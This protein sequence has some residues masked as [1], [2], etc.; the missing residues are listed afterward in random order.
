MNKVKFYISVALLNF[1]I[2][3][4]TFS[5]PI[6]FESFTD[7]YE[8]EFGDTIKIIF[9]IHNKT[10]STITLYFATTC[11]IDYYIDEFSYLSQFTCLQT[12]TT[13]VLNPDTT[14]VYPI[15]HNNLF[16]LPKVGIHDFSGILIGY[17]SL[18][19]IFNVVKATNVIEENLL[20]KYSLFDNYPNPFNPSTAI[21]FQIPKSGIVSLK[22]YDVLGNEV[23]TLV[24]EEKPA[25]IYEVDFDGSELTSGIYFYVLA[26]NDFRE[27]KKMV[28]LK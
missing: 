6:I 4:A 7:K 11:A 8:Y 26:S 25:G 24:N 5:Q 9:S 22:V 12:P 19:S 16:Y 28:L 20:R 23:A 14:I 21:K 18:S 10:D 27:S 3:A 13:I 17:D 2:S 1:L 15:N